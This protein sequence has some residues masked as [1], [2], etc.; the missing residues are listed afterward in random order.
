MQKC[1]F[2]T[3]ERDGRKVYYEVAEPHLADIMSCIEKR[4]L[5]AEGN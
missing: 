4:F 2:F 1:G 5:S 3:S